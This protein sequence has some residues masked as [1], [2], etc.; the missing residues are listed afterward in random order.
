MKK[1]LTLFAL[2]VLT[3]TGAQ[4]QTVISDVSQI[5]NNKS[6]TVNSKNRGSWTMNT[7]GTALRSDG[8]SGV[9]STAKQWAFVTY[10]SKTYLYNVETKKFITKKGTEAAAYHDHLTAVELY[11]YQS[12]EM[13]GWGASY[14]G[15]QAS[16]HYFSARMGMDGTYN[17]YINFGSSKNTTVD[18]WGPGNAPGYNAKCGADEGNALKITEAADFDPTEAL[19]ALDKYF[20]AQYTIN[21]DKETVSTHDSR[22]TNMVGLDNSRFSWTSQTGDFIYRDFTSE[23]LT[24]TAGTSVTPYIGFRG[25]AMYGYLYIDYNNDGDFEDDGELVSQMT[26]NTWANNTND[27]TIPAFTVTNTPGTYRARFK[28]EWN[29]T[30]PGGDPGVGIAGNGGSITDVMVKVVSLKDILEAKIAE[31]QGLYTTLSDGASTVAIGYPTS[32]ALQAFQNAIDAAQAVA[33]ADQGG[34]EDATSALEGAMTDVKS[35]GNTNYTPRTDVY[36]T[37][38]SARGSMVYDPSHSTDVDGAGNEFLWY[39]NSLDKTNANHQWGFIK[40]GDKYYMYNVGKVLFAGITQTGSYQ[41]DHVK[42]NG[43]YHSDRGTWMFSN[44]P[45][46]VTLDAGYNNWVATPNCRIQAT[47]DVTGNTYSMSISTSYVGPVIAYDDVND[48]GIPMTFAVA[49]T[50]QDA[51]VTAAIEALL[52]DLTPFREALQTAIT[53][54]DAV[55]ANIGTGL[56]QYTAT[57]DKSAFDTALADAKTEAAKADNETSKADLIAKREA[58]ENAQAALGLSLNMPQAN[59]FL[60]IKSV[61]N[62]YVSSMTGEEK[63][64]SLAGGGYATSFTTGGDA[65]AANTIWLY[66]GSHLISYAT[67]LYSSNCSADELGVAEPKTY[68]FSEATDVTGKYWIKPSNGNYWYGGTPTIDNYSTTVGVNATRF[69]LE[70]V[71]ELPITLSEVNGKYYRTFSAPVDIANITGATMNNVTVATDNKTASTVEMTA[72]NGLVAGNGVVLIGTSTTATATIGTAQ[73]SATTN[74]KPQYASEPAS[75]H[76][77]HYF[78]GTKTSNSEKVVGFYLLKD[79]GKT[80]GFKAYIE[81]N[82]STAKEGFDLVFGNE[83]T[84]IDAIENGADNGAVFN[85]QGQRVNKAQKGV[86]IQNGKKVIVR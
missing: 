59:T 67:G 47:S 4:A 40:K 21:F 37:I 18:G 9:S 85:L 27:K 48:G 12:N 32:D 1:I 73:A 23:T 74:L 31:A 10:N 16:G 45:S 66:D 11:K 71:T 62:G 26:G 15:Y 5:S 13:D 36:Y 84:G 28:V 50:T 7:A 54:A 20:S 41:S 30:N 79:T 76:A 25:W 49:T 3:V 22:Y 17:A 82:A 44:A 56:N 6:Y 38:T 80:G 39:T 86:Y 33:D 61:V 2:L 58:L 24:V 65:T 75:A 46:S 60:R 72:T 55:D 51:A 57:G 34:Y 64:P 19:S 63:Q 81:K 42:N 29:N 68:A 77:N 35:V 52:E 83:V 14:D 70:A 53:A 78:L 69:E 43:T 8:A